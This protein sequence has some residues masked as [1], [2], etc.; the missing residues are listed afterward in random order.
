MSRYKSIIG[1]TMRS[2]T[3]AGQEVETRIAVTI[4]NRMLHLGRPDAV[5]AA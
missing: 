5:R 1:D 2:H 3:R 4:L